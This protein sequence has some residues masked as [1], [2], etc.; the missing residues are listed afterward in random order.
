MTCDPNLRYLDADHVEAPL[1]E[2]GAAD[3]LDCQGQKMG[4]IDGVLV[5]PGQRKAVYLVIR[6]GRIGAHRELLPI[7]DLHIE[8]NGRALRLQS[9]TAPL[10]RFDP[11]RYPTFSDDDLL[12][13]MFASRA[14]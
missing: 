8:A 11:R 9:E 10:E 3:I 2:F 6:R 12:T 13:A 14:A 5:D 4:S 1:T 7:A